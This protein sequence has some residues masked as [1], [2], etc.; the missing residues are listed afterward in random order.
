M[1]SGRPRTTAPGYVV[2]ISVWRSLDSAVR[3]TRGL[4]PARPLP[5][6]GC[7]RATVTHWLPLLLRFLRL[8]SAQRPEQS[9]TLWSPHLAPVL[10]PSHDFHIGSR[11]E[12]NRPHRARALSHLRVRLSPALLLPQLLGSPAP[13]ASCLRPR[14]SLAPQLPLA[15]M[16]S[17]SM[18]SLF[19][20][21]VP[22]GLYSQV[23]ISK[24]SS[25]ILNFIT[26]H[27]AL[28]LRSPSVSLSLFHSSP[29][30][31]SASDI[32]LFIF[33]IS[34]DAW[35]PPLPPTLSISL[36]HG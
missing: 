16:S 22:P 35:S 19:P 14:R 31:P 12:V 13:S 24:S 18:A 1:L 29:L 17:S 7:G 36:E 23:T 11:G 3:Q 26:L 25:L 4:S 20:P 10:Q 5:L 15:G 27:T 30:Y 21:A 34:L 6:C 28:V 9:F 8:S 33:S 2:R 32:W